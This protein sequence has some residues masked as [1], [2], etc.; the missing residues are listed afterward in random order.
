M[1]QGSKVTAVK[2]MLRSQS[3]PILHVSSYYAMKYIRNEL[4]KNYG[5]C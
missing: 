5:L 1:K 3:H 4:E 2:M